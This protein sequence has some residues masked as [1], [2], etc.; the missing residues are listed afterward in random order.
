MSK[1]V[2]SPPNRTGYLLASQRVMGLMPLLPA[3]RFSQCSSTFSPREVMTPRP[4][5]TTRLLVMRSYCRLPIS[6]CQLEHTRSAFGNRQSA[7]CSLVRMFLD[8]IDGLPDRLDFF[9]LLV[10]DGKFELVLE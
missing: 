10:G 5:M 3:Q 8:V 7:I 9:G 6:D 4:V 1:C 2:H